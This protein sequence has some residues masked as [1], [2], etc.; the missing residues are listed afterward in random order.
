M[1]AYIKFLGSNLWLGEVCTDDTNWMQDGQSMIVQGLVDK[2]NESNSR[3]SYT[4]YM[5][6]NNRTM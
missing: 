5:C 3:V 6:T 2:P 4:K 1:G